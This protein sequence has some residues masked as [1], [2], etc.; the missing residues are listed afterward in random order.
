ML[1]NFNGESKTYQSI[2]GSLLYL[3]MT[4]VTLTFTIQQFNVLR[5]YRDT[6]FFSAEL[7]N[8]FN[9]THAFTEEDGLQIAF[10]IVEIAD[11]SGRPEDTR[12]LSEYLEIEAGLKISEWADDADPSKGILKTKFSKQVFDVHPCT[13][14][15]L[16]KFY[17]LNRASQVIES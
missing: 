16:A 5:E 3:L 7:Q 4:M 14:A 12:P 6:N 11:R 15:E 17:P 10:A 8:F 1:F 2:L 9:E 13:E